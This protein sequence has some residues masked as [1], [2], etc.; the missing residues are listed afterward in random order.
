MIDHITFGARDLAR[1]VRFYDEALE[2]LGL[3]RLVDFTD[4]AGDGVRVVGYGD[5]RPW[6][7][8]MDE[9]PTEGALHVAFRADSLAKVD[10]FH[11][12][13]LRAGG[14]DNGTPGL[15]AHYHADYYAAFVLDP[16]GHNIEAVCH[17][18]PR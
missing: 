3:A 2:P 12:A 1:S 7:W 5:A 13:A 4:D 18:K 6:F 8:I 10:A 17:G 15:R 16:E 9:R 11:A 14:A